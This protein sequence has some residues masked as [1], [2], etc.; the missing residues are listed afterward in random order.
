MA[1]AR[2]KKANRN[3]YRCA[4]A[5]FGNLQN[6]L[7]ERKITHRSR[8][9][10]NTSST[11]SSFLISCDRGAAAVDA[12]EQDDDVQTFFHNLASK[13]CDLRDS[14]SWQRI[15][16][17]PHHAYSSP[18]DPMAAICA[19]QCCSSLHGQLTLGSTPPSNT[20]RAWE[21]GRRYPSGRQKR[22]LK[23][24]SRS[25]ASRNETQQSQVA[26]AVGHVG[27]KQPIW[28]INSIRAPEYALKAMQSAGKPMAHELECRMIKFHP[29]SESGS[30]GATQIGLSAMIFA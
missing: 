17:P 9:H 27:C 4:F 30:L 29:G 12:L 1:K 20:A 8:R 22:R 10:R 3:W 16:R 21:N 18:A 6:A 7:D 15:A 13:A 26:R 5:A 14:V 11:T 25:R 24:R 23:A 28:P 19:E 2:A